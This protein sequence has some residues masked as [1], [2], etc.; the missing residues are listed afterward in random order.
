MG[1]LPINS[2]T[3]AQELS[4]I[5]VDV[6][7]FGGGFAG[8]VAA[9]RAAQLGLNAVVLE[10]QPEDVYLCNSRYSTG[11]SNVVSR[12][13]ELPEAEL[14]TAINEVSAGHADPELVRVFA[15]NAGRAVTWLRSEGARLVPHPRRKK[16]HR[17]PSLVL[18]PVR[19]LK[20]GLAWQGS[21]SDVL[22]RRLETNLIG[23]G[24]SLVRGTRVVS[25]VMK[26]GA[27]VGVDA[28][29]NGEEVRYH[30]RA[31]VIADG[32]FMANRDLV[33]R[34]ITPHPEKLNL[35][36]AGN[37]KG[38]GIQMA[39]RVGAEIKGLGGFYG[40]LQHRD[41]LSNPRLWPY[42]TLDVLA[43]AGIVVG[44]DGRRFADEGRGGVAL[45]NA[46]AKLTDPLSTTVIFDAAI[47]QGPGTRGTVP[48]NPHL[49]SAGG[50][51]VVANDLAQLAESAGLPVPHLRETIEAYNEALARG[52]LATLDPPRTT[53]D[54]PAHPIGEG[55]LYAVPLC[56]GITGTMGGLS[57]NDGAQV[58]RPDGSAIPGLFAAGTA[59]GGLE[60]GPRLT[61]MGGLSK[62]FIFGLLAAESIAKF[63]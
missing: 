32:G 51:P 30:A 53:N 47:W 5:E 46:V 14:V 10:Q 4:A 61:Y 3:G 6:V 29:T 44:V 28:V 2:L 19:G 16:D 43:T 37:V 35:R 24:G 18:A 36:S 58:L 22:L 38:D 17:P 26:N 49:E 15:A 1:N 41:A 25:L 21:G 63:G 52:T 20:E 55:R 62:A 40:H 23:R 12:S 39:E 54:F 27:C 13:A 42:P 33:R 8:L 50:A 9:N 31:V 7:A 56:A 60:G 45:A 59:T 11:V 48:P 34:H 57:I